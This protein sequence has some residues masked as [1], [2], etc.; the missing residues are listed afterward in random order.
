MDYGS[1]QGFLMNCCKLPEKRD[2]IL[3]IALE[4]FLHAEYSFRGTTWNK[5]Q[6]QREQKV[7]GIHVFF[8]ML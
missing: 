2:T 5:E 4:N 7:K 8:R 1:F 3:I 6:N